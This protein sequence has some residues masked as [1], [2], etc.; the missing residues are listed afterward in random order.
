M[1]KSKNQIKARTSFLVS[2]LLMLFLPGCA[3]PERKTS[4][5]VSAPA[6]A[7]GNVENGRNLFMG[8]AH[9]END[10]PPCMGCHSVGSNGLLGGGAM[11]PDLTD[12][13]SKRSNTALAS[14][15]SNYGPELSPVMQP[16]YTAHPLTVDEQA[17]LIAFLLSSKGQ[18]ESD[19]ELIVVSISLM[20]SVV[21][22]VVIGFIYRGRM[23]GA[24]RPL[25]NKAQKELL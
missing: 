15:L 19:M 11:G 4:Q 14:I 18:P 24:R 7:A 22:A 17:D 16:I 21:A 6:I 13:S 9:F 8:Y 23:R 5:P 3:A 20:G 12:V 25:V 2:A 10:G 1:I